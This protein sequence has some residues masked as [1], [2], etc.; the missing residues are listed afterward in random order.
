MLRDDAVVHGDQEVASEEE[1]DV[2]RREPARAH[3]AV[4]PVEDQVEVV[5]ILLDLRKL[6][7]AAR[8]FD[9]RADG[10]ERRRSAARIRRRWALTRSTHSLTGEDGSSQA[11][12]TLSASFRDT[13]LVNVDGNQFARF[14][15]ERRLRRREPRDRHPVRRAAH[16]VE[17]HLLEEVNRRRVSA[18]LTADAQLDVGPCRASFRHGDVHELTDTGLIDRGERVLLDDLE[19][20][21]RSG[22]TSPSRRATCRG[23]SA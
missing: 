8:V 7:C 20:L 3:L 5:G 16:V 17:P 14:H 15:R 6:E 12:S 23:R 22:G 11:G 1:V 4:D 21:S 2:A 19:L 9:R 13:T 18:V 10:S